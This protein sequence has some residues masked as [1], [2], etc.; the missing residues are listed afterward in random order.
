MKRRIIIIVVIVAVVA[1]GVYW[2]VMSRPHGVTLTGIVAT[3]DVQVSSQV[4]GRVQ[5]LLVRQGD[6]VKKGQLLAVILPEELQADKAYYEMSERESAAQV[7]QA[8]ADL[9]LQEEQ[10]REQIRQATAN[11]AMYNAQVKQA[12]ADLELARITFN[13]A[14]AMRDRNINSQQDY[15]QARANY[16]ATMARVESLRKQAKAAV[17]ALAL[18]RAN[19]DQVEARRA[20]LAASIRHLAAAGAQNAKAGVVLGYTDIR[21]PIDGIVDVRAALQGEVVAPGQGIVSLIDPDDLWV[22][23]DVEEGYIDRIRLG[24]KLTVRLPSGATREGKVFFRGVDADY[25]TQRDVSRTKRD[26]KTFEIRLRC[27]N[28]DRALAL[29]MTAYVILPVR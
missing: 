22:R 13:R 16:D 2:W 8:K 1:A 20:A 19:A 17:A 25:A 21:A 5:S 15:D 26:I 6:N 29:G 24:D 27:D 12:E 18:A 4:Q 7:E 14:K 9:K 23:A 28:R 3:D 10:T 11:L